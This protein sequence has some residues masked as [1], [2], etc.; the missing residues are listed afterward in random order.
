MPFSPKRSKSL[1]SDEFID[2]LAGSNMLGCSKGAPKRA[3]KGV[4]DGPKI[5]QTTLPNGGLLPLPNGPKWD[6]NFSHINHDVRSFQN[7]EKTS[8]TLN[9]YVLTMSGE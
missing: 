6:Q 3:R 7:R 1:K 8:K 9:I 4:S 2:V 5:T